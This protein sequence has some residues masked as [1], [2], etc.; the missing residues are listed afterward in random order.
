MKKLFFAA[1]ILLFFSNST[2]AQ[3]GSSEP[4]QFNPYLL[5]SAQDINPQLMLFIPDTAAQIQ[6]NPARAVFYQKRF[7]YGTY[8]AGSFRYM[9]T[10]FNPRYRGSNYNFEKPTIAF[11]ALLNGSGKK[12]LINFTNG[13]NK[14]EDEYNYNYSDLFSPNY[15]DYYYKELITNDW[16]TENS[17]S[18]LKISMIGNTGFGGYSLSLFGSY[19]RL[20][21]DRD[22]SRNYVSRKKR[23]YS[24]ENQYIY[25]KYVDDIV[26]DTFHNYQYL[27]G[28]EFTLSGKDWDF[29][30]SLSWQRLDQHYKEYQYFVGTNSDTTIYT[31]TTYYREGMTKDLDNISIHKEP[32]YI[33]FN[34]YF[35]RR[36]NLFT[37]KDYIFLSLKAVY[38]SY[39]INYDFNSLD[40]SYRRYNGEPAYGDTLEVNAK[41]KEKGKYKKV[42]F[43][44]GYIFEK[45]LDDI[46]IFTGINPEISYGETKDMSGNIRR[47]GGRYPY[48]YLNPPIIDENTVIESKIIFPFY[49]NYTPVK[50]FSMFGIF[51]YT[52][53]HR[54]TEHEMSNPA[55]TIINEGWLDSTEN[56]ITKEKDT[57]IL[58]SKQFCM[59]SILRHKSG[60]VLQI[61][62]NSDMAEYSRWNFSL[63]YHF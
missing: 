15:E 35:R 8:S 4:V 19:N 63:G 51:N 30:S 11:S 26:Q 59:G 27:L 2:I 47:G 12:W 37:K 25:N 22:Y 57:Y 1:L 13:V 61:A 21:S 48:Y 6:F 50:W 60:L 41:D 55:G 56:N 42:R 17:V 10:I 58:S 38:A 40:E 28:L 45:N 29:I 39:D 18:S 34:S 33:N 9:E 32:D 3:Y 43:S 53:R 62:F 54:Y 44:L 46:Y 14:G 20:Q 36:M 23:V 16:D 7:V 52:Y 24:S 5:T 31:D 49:I